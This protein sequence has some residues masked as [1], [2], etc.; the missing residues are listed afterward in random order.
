M[1]PI[2]IR[3]LH[4]A[5]RYVAEGLW[6]QRAVAP[7][8]ETVRPALEWAMEIASEG[9]PLP[10]IGFIADVGHIALGADVEIKRKLPLAIR[11]LPPGW[12]IAY[13]DHVLGKLYADWTFERAGDALR[14]Y[15]TKE[16]IKGLAYIVN[17]LRERLGSGG[18]SLP[19]AVIRGL[20]ALNPDEV[21]A[22]AWE[23]LQREGISTYLIAQYEAVTKAGRRLGEVLGAED[24]IALEQR[25]AL[26]DLGQYVAHR[27]ILQCAA[28]LD[29]R[30]PS[31]PVKPRP[32]R[33]EVPTRVHD[34]DQYPVGG[35]TSIATKGSIESLLHSQLA[36]IEDASPGSGP[37]LFDLKYARDELFYYSRDENQF[38]RRRRA[39]AFVFFPT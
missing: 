27:Q 6:L 11:G 36:Y 22:S 12:D 8:P 7:A 24:I 20:I 37:D 4:E 13:D 21:L 30:L 38:L 28:R 39:F 19:P 31:R 2:E 33:R 35:Y 15:S 17:R 14:G 1:E 23:G 26:A 18:V 16:R 32:G 34:E 3:D 10:P 25:T 5:R 9:Q 29:E